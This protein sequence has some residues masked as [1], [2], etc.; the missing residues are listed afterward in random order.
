MKSEIIFMVKE[1]LEGGYEAIAL[2]YPIFTQA[3]SMDLLQEKGSDAVNCHFKPEDKP[4]AICLHFVK[5][6]VI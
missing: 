3:E 4:K 6:V 2:G 5:D 1:S